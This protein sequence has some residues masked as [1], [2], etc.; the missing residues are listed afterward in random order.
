MLN[1]CSV[2]LSESAFFKDLM[3]FNFIQLHKIA[4]IYALAIKGRT[5]TL[6]F[7]IALVRASSD[8]MTWYD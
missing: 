4:T 3:Q 2:F 8:L 6:N 1:V 5:S 7:S